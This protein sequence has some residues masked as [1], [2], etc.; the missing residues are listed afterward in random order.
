LGGLAIETRVRPY[1]NLKTMRASRVQI[2][3]FF[4]KVAKRH[5]P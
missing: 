3:D 4:L 5:E 2:R 1:I